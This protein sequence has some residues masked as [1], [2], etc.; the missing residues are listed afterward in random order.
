VET[1]VVQQLAQS[2][3]E[4]GTDQ[5]RTLLQL[6]ALL[7]MLADHVG[8]MFFPEDIGWRIVGRLAFPLYAY[9]LVQGYLHT[10]HIVKYLKRMGWLALLSQI[11]FMLAINNSLLHQLQSLPW[12][13]S[14]WITER[15]LY[16]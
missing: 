6:S 9:S 11:P 14:L 4:K 13:G 1:G 8:Y 7:T 16:C 2:P 15:M 3:K 10:S 5:G 12:N